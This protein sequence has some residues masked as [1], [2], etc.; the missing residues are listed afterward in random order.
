MGFPRV[1]A[2]F[3][4]LPLPLDAMARALWF[5]RLAGFLLGERKLC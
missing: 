3:A 5:L 1:E 2:P 4:K